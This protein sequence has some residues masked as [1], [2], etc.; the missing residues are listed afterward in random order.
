MNLLTEAIR[1][2]DFT[3]A[4]LLITKF[5]RS[6]LGNKVY[7]YPTP[8][9]FTPAGGSKRVGIRFFIID[10]GA[11][12]VRLNWK[13]VGKIGSQGLDQIDYWDGSK[14][15]QPN[16]S[17]HIKL[18]H[19]QSLVKILPMIVDLI[20][21]NLEKSG[22]F[23][24]E[25]VQ[26][27]HMPMVTDFTRVAEL[28][29]ASYT[30]G[31]ISKT[32]HAV[33]AAW[34]QGIHQND[35]YKAGGSKKYGAGWNKI[36]GIIVQLYPSILQKQGNKNVVNLDVAAKLDSAKIMA[37]LGGDGEVVAYQVQPGS[38]EEVEVDGASDAD[39]DRMTYEEQLESL[40]TGIRLM[41]SRATNALFLAGRGGTGKTE[42]TE[43]TLK[44]FGKTDG[45]GYIKVAGS[46]TPAGIY[47][48]LFKHRKDTILFDDCDSALQDQEGRN[49]FKAAPD[50][51]RV[52]KISWLKGGKSYVDPDD[53]DWDAEEPGDEL[54]RSFE[55]TGQIIFISNLKL[56]KLDPD[57]ALRT[58]GYIINIDPTNEEIYDFMVKICDKIP[59]E[60]D[61]PL[62]HEDRVEVIEIIKS[63]KI[64]EKSANLRTLV[65]GL[66]TRAGVEKTGGGKDQWMKFVKMFA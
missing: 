63:R 60:V 12:S 33:I 56:D 21:G 61:Y 32:L 45:D 53:Y 15:P 4:Q 47:R 5:L 44:E 25:S 26:L 9:V 22:F 36:N 49:L 24:N 29:E 64:P 7:P 50:T 65:R 1:S 18:D 38:K 35:Q 2:K 46:A 51:K 19:E 43:R 3:S 17:H 54:P 28:N 11:K 6:K 37:S 16:P 55:F 23:M 8:E 30:S 31:E 14:A 59:L 58:R 10:G 62:S 39:I 42:T 48:I 34:K 41:V 40:E 57:G 52:R 13:T 27:Q 20:H 66:N